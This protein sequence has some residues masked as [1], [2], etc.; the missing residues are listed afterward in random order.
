VTTASVEL[1]M[2]SSARGRK[3]VSTSVIPPKAEVAFAAEK[4]FSEK[5]KSAE[6][7][8]RLMQEQIT[9]FEEQISKW[10]QMLESTPN[11]NAILGCVVRDRAE[12]Q[13]A[14]L[15]LEQ[16]RLQVRERQ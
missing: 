6:E 3:Q 15:R 1:K 12:L 11:D 16:Y 5:P 2:R 8:M 9:H 13:N 4:L 10:N 14:K 7:G